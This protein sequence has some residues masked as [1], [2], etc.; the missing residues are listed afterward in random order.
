MVGL[1]VYRL[2]EALASVRENLIDLVQYGR[3][4]TGS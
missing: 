4:A 1:G 3:T 2:H